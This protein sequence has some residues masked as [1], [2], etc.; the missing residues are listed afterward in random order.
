MFF[1][2]SY[3]SLFIIQI[4]PT[5][6]RIKKKRKEKQTVYFSFYSYGEFCK[7]IF[8]FLIRLVFLCPEEVLGMG[9][10]AREFRI[11]SAWQK[12]KQN[13]QFVTKLLE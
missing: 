13:L 4:W 1:P 11:T 5:I 9:S 6:L 12:T 3:K 10:L 8:C 2:A 7:V